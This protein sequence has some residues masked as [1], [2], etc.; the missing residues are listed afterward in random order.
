M[1]DKNIARTRFLSALATASKDKIVKEA[2]L[3]HT[4][5]AMK[6]PTI[7]EIADYRKRSRQTKQTVFDLTLKN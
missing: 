2:R 6:E 5:F 3:A 7:E 1:E 4:A